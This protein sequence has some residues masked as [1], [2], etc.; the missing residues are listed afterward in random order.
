MD[1][2]LSSHKVQL[3]AFQMEAYAGKLKE[4]ETLFS[5]TDG[6]LKPAGRGQMEAALRATEELVDDLQYD[7]E[8]LAGQ[9]S[10]RP[11]FRSSLIQRSMAK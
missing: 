2:P 9:A 1:E 6:G 8:L 5:E 3:F 11:V 10:I 4:L 7:T